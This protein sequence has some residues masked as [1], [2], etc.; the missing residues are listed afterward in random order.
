MAA[1]RTF[2]AQHFQHLLQFL[3]IG[4]ELKTALSF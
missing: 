2:L 4:I 1:D 3:L